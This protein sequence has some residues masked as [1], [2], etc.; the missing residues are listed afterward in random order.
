[1]S[2]ITERC[3]E[4]QKEIMRAK[5]AGSP[6]PNFTDELDRMEAWLFE[7]GLWRDSHEGYPCP[8]VDHCRCVHRGCAH[9]WLIESGPGRTAAG[10]ESPAVARI[11]PECQRAQL[12]MRHAKKSKPA[13]RSHE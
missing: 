9:G 1:M 8:W 13:R 12:L 4:I 3:R 5:A 11:C 6:I 2:R 7:R 10:R